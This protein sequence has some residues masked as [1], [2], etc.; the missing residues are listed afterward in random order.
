MSQNVFNRRQYTQKQHEAL[1]TLQNLSSLNINAPQILI[2]INTENAPKDLN[3]PG[4]FQHDDKDTF[5]MATSAQPNDTIGYL[6]QKNLVNLNVRD[7]GYF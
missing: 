6:S 4:Y 3:E 7:G 2:R 1:T 5:I